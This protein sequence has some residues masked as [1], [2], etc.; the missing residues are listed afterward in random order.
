MTD[1]QGFGATDT[2][3]AAAHRRGH[4]RLLRARLSSRELDTD[5][6]GP[7]VR[8]PCARR[9]GPASATRPIDA[10]TVTPTPTS[11]RSTAGPEPHAD[12]EI[13]AQT[14]WDPAA[15]RSAREARAPDRHRGA[16]DRAAASRRSS[17]CAT[18]SCRRYDGSDAALSGPSSPPAAWATSPPRTAATTSHPVADDTD[19]AALTATGRRCRDGARRGRHAAR[20][21]ARRHR[22]PGHRRPRPVLA[23]DT[24][25]D[26]QLR[27]HRAV[28]GQRYPL[29]FAV[30]SPRTR[31]SAPT[32]VTF[33]RDRATS[34]SCATSPRPPAA[35]AVASL[36]RAR[37]TPPSGCGPGGLIDD[38]GDTV[39]AASR[40]ACR[41]SWS[42]SA[43]R[44]TSSP[45]RSTPSAGCGDDQTRRARRL[46]GARRPP[47]PARSR[48]SPAAPSRA[49]DL[50]TPNPV[51]AASRRA[52]ATCSCARSRRRIRTGDSGEDFLDVAEL[53]VGSA[54][55]ARPWAPRST[56]APPRT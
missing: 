41:R 28:A 32:N 30:A 56:P 10:A 15:R 39:G 48:R 8:R 5:G 43:R 1:A 36:Q 11:G 54:C 33:P 22:G 46:P 13:W 3:Q 31:E 18:R 24:G 50:G 42:T 21:R 7:D 38:S 26:G 55:P 17:T 27:D 23:D 52:C 37:T 14:L 40:A 44:S 9:A 16:A 4:E 19:P 45:S 2:A 49:G 47:R 35:R 12:G 6:D 29:S 34:R 20:R 25:R 53:H 51:A